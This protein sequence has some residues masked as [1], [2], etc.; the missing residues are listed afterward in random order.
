MGARVRQVQREHLTDEQWA[1]F[2]R[3]MEL[4]IRLKR[5]IRERRAAQRLSGEDIYRD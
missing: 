1:D 5:R 3:L 2:C 4:S